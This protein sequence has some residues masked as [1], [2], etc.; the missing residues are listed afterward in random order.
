MTEY[1]PLVPLDEMPLHPPHGP[2]QGKVWAC[3]ALPGTSNLAVSWD[4]RCRSCVDT[5][6]GMIDAY[7]DLDIDWNP[8]LDGRAVRSLSWMVERS[9]YWFEQEEH[10]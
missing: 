9:R 10:A 5:A 3:N 7:G 4:W 8:P 6:I 2:D 1:P